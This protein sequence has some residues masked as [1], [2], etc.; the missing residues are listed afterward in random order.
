MGQHCEEETEVGE[1]LVLAPEKR[2]RPVL[3]S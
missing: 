2:T 1:D 3:S